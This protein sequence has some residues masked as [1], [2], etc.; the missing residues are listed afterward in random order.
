MRETTMHC[1]FYTW[2]SFIK[3]NQKFT[4]K[5]DP[6]MN[7]PCDICD[8][9]KAT[10]N[11]PKRKFR[12]PHRNLYELVDSDICEMPVVSADGYKY[13]MLF[14]DDSSRYSHTSLLRNNSDIYKSFLDIIDEG[15]LSISSVRSDQSTKYLSK[16]LESICI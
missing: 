6:S 13:F 8:A 16:T 11:T 7:C 12:K 9:T 14:V 2:S 15:S 4:T 10:R 3:P 5:T 1:T